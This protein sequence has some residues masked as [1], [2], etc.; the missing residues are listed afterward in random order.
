MTCA[1]PPL[2]LQIRLEAQK[3]EAAQAQQ[4]ETEKQLAIARRR[5]EQVRCVRAFCA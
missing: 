4:Q 1:P 5:L 2:L 3:L